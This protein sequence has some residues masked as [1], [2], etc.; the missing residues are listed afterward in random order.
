MLM[1]LGT[2]LR[3]RLPSAHVDSRSTARWPGLVDT[4]VAT[5]ARCRKDQLGR[6][7]HRDTIGHGARRRRGRR[8]LAGGRRRCRRLERRT[9]APQR[10]RSPR[11]RHCPGRRLLADQMQNSVNA[12]VVGTGSASEAMSHVIE[13]VAERRRSCASSSR[14]SIRTDRRHLVEIQTGLAEAGSLLETQGGARR[15]PAGPGRAPSRRSSRRSPSLEAIPDQLRNAQA[16]LTDSDGSASTTNSACGARRSCSARSRCC[17]AFFV[18]GS[19]GAV[20]ADGE[21]DGQ[22]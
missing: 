1:T 22:P 3:A 11:N 10:P 19:P 20:A 12:L 13:I 9:I 2:L 16:D 15:D 4:G 18:V 17:S 21:S 14:A 8:C 5:M 7:R 6:P